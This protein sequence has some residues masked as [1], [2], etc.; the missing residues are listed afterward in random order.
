[1][2]RRWIVVGALLLTLALLL[3][4]ADRG[5]VP[6]VAVARV[7]RGDLAAWIVTNGR[8][9][10]IDPF[11]VRARFDGF[12]Q[13][14]PA[15]EGQTLHAGGV[16]LSM[17]MAPV[18]ADLARARAQLVG[19]QDDLQAARHGGRP[20]DVARLEAELRKA[21][22]E[23]DRLRRE[24]AALERLVQRQAA[25]R[26][27]L[28]ANQAALARADAE[29]ER[30]A[31]SKAEFE[32]RTGVDSRRTGFL[33]DRARAEV[34][35][36]EQRRAAAVMRAPAEGVLY[37]LRVH[38]H[39]Y[40][41]VGDLLAEMADL[42]RVRVRSFVDEPE[43][44]RF[45]SGA[46][47]EVSWDGR[48]GRVWRGVAGDAPSQIVP[49]GVRSVGEVVCTVDNEPREL[50]PNA[51]VDVRIRVADR[52]GVLVV[53]RAALH[54]AAERRYVFVVTG[55]GPG[56]AA[57]LVE[58][59]VKIGIAGTNA[60]EVVGGLAEGDR[61]A[62]PGDVPLRNGLAVRPGESR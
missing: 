14:V 48:P 47:V 36:L 22:A 40:V 15:T 25:T 29:R 5:R 21:E 2:K 34:D 24:R 31:K 54:A 23:S 60:A 3:A 62:L 46:P 59:D 32:R 61:V 30:L 41:R 10:P 20:D 50:V 11:V 6:S 58:R 4:I 18:K 42:R 1:M 51:N 13:G 57:R 45:T 28:D 19:A 12:I 9:E 7:T 27:E 49:L 56:F 39:D 33:A 55:G 26:D 52:H 37:S 17:D 16:L 8:V 43:L 38:P 44:S 35:D 53:P